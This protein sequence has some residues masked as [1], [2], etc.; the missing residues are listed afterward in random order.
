MQLSS[1]SKQLSIVL[2]PAR[3]SMWDRRVGSDSLGFGVKPISI[4]ISPNSLG[5][6]SKEVRIQL[7][8]D[9]S[10]GCTLS[11]VRVLYSYNGVRARL[12]DIRAG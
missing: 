4:Q 10:K 6:E 12:A 1:R 2:D 11:P 5:L 8:I 9:T 7:L 3:F